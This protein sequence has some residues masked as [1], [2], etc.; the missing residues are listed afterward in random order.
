[1]PSKTVITNNVTGTVIN[2]K[3]IINV[4]PNPKYVHI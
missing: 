2:V 3:I 1:M 4:D